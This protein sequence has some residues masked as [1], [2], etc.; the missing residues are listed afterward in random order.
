MVT[1]WRRTRDGARWYSAHRHNSRFC[2]WSSNQ[3]FEFTESKRIV[4]VRPNSTD[5]AIEFNDQFATYDI[6]IKGR[7]SNHAYF[8]GPV[9]SH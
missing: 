3:V 6:V 7:N 1:W 2:A 4:G 5:V 8:R 9:R